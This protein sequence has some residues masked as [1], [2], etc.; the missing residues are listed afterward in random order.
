M[1]TC[2]FCG[3]VDN[4][5]E[6]TCTGTYVHR[7]CIESAGL[8]KLINE[9]FPLSAGKLRYK[10]SPELSDGCH[11][12]IVDNPQAVLEAVK[13]WCKEAKYY[14]EGE[15]FTVEIVKMTDEEVAK[16]PYI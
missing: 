9:L 10:L 2:S 13:D 7:A 12:T 1:F 14:G 11:S 6:Q 16:L 3:R 15:S 8:G 5:V 4:K